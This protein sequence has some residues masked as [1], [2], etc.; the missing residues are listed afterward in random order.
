VTTKY[1]RSGTQSTPAA[2]LVTVHHVS[3]REPGGVP[4]P[5]PNSLVGHARRI[6]SLD[7]RDAVRVAVVGVAASVPVFGGI[8]AALLDQYLPQ[9]QARRTTEFLEELAVATG[10]IEDRLDHEFVRTDEFQGLLEEALERVSSRRAEG[11]RAAYAAAVAHGATTARPDE[12]ERFRMLDTLE[13]L[14]ASQIR[15]LLYF[16][17]VPYTT[18][19]TLDSM[20]AKIAADTAMPLDALRRDWGDLASLHLVEYDDGRRHGMA[21][22]ASS[23]SAKLTPFARSFVNFIG[24]GSLGRK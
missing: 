4:R 11:K 9:A 8:A 5:G 14:R 3:M 18:L 2:P 7:K 22:Q 1:K 12:D 13:R 16:Q 17:R 15:L 21:D 6:D 23:P 10:G 19:A 24:D 20:G